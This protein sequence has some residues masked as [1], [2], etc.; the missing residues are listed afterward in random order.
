M[1]GF[2]QFFEGLK[3][4]FSLTVILCD[5]SADEYETDVSW[6]EDQFH[7][8]GD[9]FDC[10][11]DPLDPVAP[12]LQELR[13]AECRHAHDGEHDSCL[14]YITPISSLAHFEQLH[15]LEVP[16]EAFAGLHQR[17]LFE[18][19]PASLRCLIVDAPSVAIVPLLESVP[20]AQ[21]LWS[22]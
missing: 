6:Y 18:V 22:L 4:L 7:S 15:I 2:K 5:M 14:G 9:C 13:I 1:E 3:G 16:C 20:V 8:I 11:I 19:L 17:P 12:T 10:L 21:E